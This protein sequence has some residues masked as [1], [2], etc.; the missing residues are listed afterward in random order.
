MSDHYDAKTG[1]FG[2][3]LTD[4]PVT[5]GDL[6]EFRQSLRDDIKD[7]DRRLEL[8]IS[9]T[10]AMQK[11]THDSLQRQL[12]QNLEQH[13]ELLGFFKEK[14]SELIDHAETRVDLMQVSQAKTDDLQDTRIGCVEEAVKKHSER[15]SALEHAPTKAKAGR[16]D[17]VAVAIGAV[18][19]AIFSAWIT[20]AVA[21]CSLPA[22]EAINAIVP[23]PQGGNSR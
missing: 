11:N 9:H 14:F 18:G 19:I 17:R 10:E 16:W 8:F 12:D 23:V 2:S 7:V 22:K 13:K 5:R 15:I 6:D 3:R 1:Q 20:A 4:A 21:Q